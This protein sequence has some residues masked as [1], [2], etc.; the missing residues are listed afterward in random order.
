[1][2][3]SFRMILRRTADDSGWTMRPLA[4]G[5]AED[6]DADQDHE[7][8]RAA[9]ARRAAAFSRGRPAKLVREAAL[10][11]VIGAL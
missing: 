11:S 6:Q 5:A 1:M 10:A 9:S 8:A 4:A 7:A 2:L 3:T